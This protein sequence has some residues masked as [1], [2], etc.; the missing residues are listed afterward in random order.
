MLNIYQIECFLTVV[1]TLNYTKAAEEFHISRQALSKTI[2]KMENELGG[3]LFISKGKTLELTKLGRI[4]EENAIPLIRAYHRFEYKMD[5]YTSSQS[6]ELTVAHAYGALL[7]LNPDE[8]LLTEYQEQYPE[9]LLSSE[10]TN[11]DGVIELLEKGEA[12]IGLIGSI[13]AYLKGFHYFPLRMTGMHMQF[14]SNH[15]LA[16]KKE[17]LPA[18]LKGFSII[19]TGKR[20]HQTRFFTESCRNCGIE[21]KFLTHTAHISKMTSIMLKTGAITFSMPES[22]IPMP[23]NIAVR[24][25]CLP[26]DEKLGTYAIIRKDTR[27][28]SCTR[29]FLNFLRGQYCES[30]LQTHHDSK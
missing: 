19:G 20:N 24:H 17:L 23:P 4:L 25:L 6:A 22:I 1:Q 9:V 28:T 29:S 30:I 21:P 13:P 11:S 5:Q 8:N 18:D 26:G 3:P 12:D 27:L 14:P 16:E 10:L 7:S 15:P 2:Q